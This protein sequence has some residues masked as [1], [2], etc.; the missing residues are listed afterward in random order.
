MLLTAASGC[1]EVEEPRERIQF[2]F[3]HQHALI[4]DDV[5]DLAGGVENV[6]E[7]PRAHRANLHARRIAPGAGALDAEGAFLH[8]AFGPG[9]VAEVVG[10]GIDLVLRHAGLGP[11]EVARAVGAG[12]HAVAAADAPVVVDHHDAILL[13]PGGAGGADLGAGRVLALLAAH[14]DVEVAI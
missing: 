9:P 14:R 5:A 1:I 13:G 11:I 3:E 4:F 6:A 10:V 2:L 12:R 8:Y 7:F